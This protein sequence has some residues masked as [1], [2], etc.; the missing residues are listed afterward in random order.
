MTR[1]D[2]RPLFVLTIVTGSFLLFLIQ[3]LVARMALPLLGG[4][5]NVWN[6]AM[7]V[8]QTLLLGGYAYAHFLAKQPRRRQA[9]VHV[10]LLAVSALSLPIA[11]ADLPPAAPGWE[12]LWVPAL[13]LATVGPVF[14]LL[15][16][17]APLMQSWYAATPDAR[18]PYPLYAASNVGSFAGL[19]AYPILLEPLLAV[20]MQ[21]V[22]FSIGFILL[23]A[24]VAL[25]GLLLRGDMAT[26]LE[27]LAPDEAAEPAPGWRRVA[28]WL[29]LS[30][31]P[32]GLMLSTTTHLTTDIM[33]MP[34]LWIIPLGLYLL[35]FTAAFAEDRTWA[36]ILSKCAPL[37]LLL[38]GTMAMQGNSLAAGQVMLG[39]V[40]LLFIVAVALH[41]RLYDLRPGSRHLTLFYF[42]MAAGG[43]LGGA[44]T[45][46]VAPVAFD[47]VY[48]HPL[49]LLAAG[50]LLAAQPLL[51]R[52][53]EMWANLRRPW[54]LSIPLVLAVAM[55]AWPLSAFNRPSTQL[56]ALIFTLLAT[57]LGVVLYGRRIAFV[58][59]LAIMMLARGGLDTIER[60]FSGDRARSYFGVYTVSDVPGRGVRELQHGTTVHGLRLLDPARTTE[61][62]AYYGRNSGVGRAIRSDF[63]VLGRTARVGVVGLGTGTIACLGDPAMDW[64]F[65]EIDPAVLRYSRNGDFEFLSSCAPDARIEIGD[66]RIRLADGAAERFDIL[67]LDAFSSDSIPLHLLTREAFAVYGRALAPDGVLMV[68]GSNR[69]IAIGDVLSGLARDGG[70]HALSLTDRTQGRALYVSEWIALS[71]D[72]VT[73]ARLRAAN[74]EADWQELPAPTGRVWTDNHA[75]IVPYIEWE[76]VWK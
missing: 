17:Q 23:I 50:A 41:S 3:P 1:T 14:L 20:P 11:L 19:L 16:A 37:L 49:L 27:R 71:R 62:T 74:P 36:E 60:S 64:T 67:A 4:A 15:S 46:L 53:A 76:K 18:D 48:E 66:A 28:L 31:V 8:F 73:L 35:S 21:S 25:V 51:P 56:I 22:V 63:A 32:S 65:F 42:V 33:A 70:W 75:S 34:L 54:L 29:A 57:M 45:A 68:H 24:L 40:L 12:V 59:V 26:G 58:A 55:I 61:P 72:P 6:S 7:L 13:I 44:F 43:A 69:Y 2:P 5:P 38:V 39:M 47:W 9:I 10:V 52:L 30:A